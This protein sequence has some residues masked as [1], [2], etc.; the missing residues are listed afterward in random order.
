[1]LSFVVVLALANAVGAVPTNSAGEKKA[2]AELKAQED[3]VKK[4]V[5][6][7]ERDR[8]QQEKRDSEKRKSDFDRSGKSKPHLPT[9]YR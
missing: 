4:D 2:K 9:P 1:L 3:Q 6:R 7:K 8:K 5:A